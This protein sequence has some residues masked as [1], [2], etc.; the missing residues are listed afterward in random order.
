MDLKI[1]AQR[2][3]TAF[4]AHLRRIDSQDISRGGNA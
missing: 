4:G 1:T 2:Y 3:V